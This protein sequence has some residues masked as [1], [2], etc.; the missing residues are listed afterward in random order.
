MHLLTELETK[1]QQ[2]IENYELK[3][4]ELEELKEQI[5]LLESQNKTL[6]EEKVAGEENQFKA[7]CLH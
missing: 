2:M 5:V 6:N 4:L 3:N 7:Y 1:I